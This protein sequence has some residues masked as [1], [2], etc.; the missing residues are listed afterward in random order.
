MK[1]TLNWL[2]QYVDFNWSPEELAER[3]TMLGLEVEGVHKLGG[4]FE[5]VVVA[6]V[7]TRDKHPNADKL[8]VCRVHDGQGERQIVC[9]AQNFQA[10]D[11]VPLVLPGAS[12]PSK[13]GEAP[14][15]IKV[16]KIR[17]V[18]SH[19]MMCSPKELGL[20]AEADGLLILPAD[21]R[22]G[23]PF[24]EHLGRSG[25]DVIYDLEIT[26]NRPDLNSVIGIAREIAAVTGNAL[27]I[28]EVR[29]QQSEVRSEDL[30]AVRIEDADLCPRYTA[31]VIRG[32]KIGPS[33]DWLRGALEKV[34]IRSIS[35]VV[36][37]TNYVM[38]ECGQPL[39]AF[40]YHLV[41]KGA[42]GKPTIVIRR[43][44]AGELFV[45]LDGQKH[46]LA[47]DNL[48]IADE[49]KGI[50][51]AGVMGGQNT[52]INERTVDVLLES[53]YFKP[54]NIRRTSKTTGLRTDASYRFERG[55]DISI[56][57]WASQRAAQL[58]LE[59]A[60]GQLAG[61]VVDAYPAPAEPRQITLRHAKVNELLGINLKPEEM[62]YY[63][64]QL[65]VRASARK[66]RPLDDTPTAPE[67][68]SFRI[69]TFRVDLKREIDLIE[70]V[71]RLHGVDK[72]PST[73]P[74]GAIGANAFDAVYD[75]IAEVR[76][77]LSGLGLSEATGQTLIAEASATLVTAPENLVPLSNPMS[78]DMNALRPSLLPGL[79]DSLRHNLTRK[80]N[81]VALFEVGRVFTM[82]N[83]QV[84]EERRV[85]MA[86]T[87]QRTPAF[88]SGGER[89]AKFDLSD[90][91]G[92][93][94]EFLEQSGL[95]GVT[96][97]RRPASTT[98]FLESAALQL[99]GKLALGEMGLLLPAL[100]KR[101]DLRDAVV[102]A[103]LSLDSL[104]ARR[105][106]A[107][108]FKTLP[109]FP[110]VRRDVA[111]FLTEEVTHDAVLGAVRQAKPQN[112]E[113]LELFDVFR[114]QHVPAGQKSVAYAFTYR[115]PDRTLTDNEVNAAHEKVVAQFKQALG[116]TV[117]E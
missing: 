106:A 61:G 71:A 89:D 6:Q 32:V 109:Q 26:P 64:N 99:G 77:I 16:G 54:T 44:Q 102:L 79:L 68:V 88:W 67:P 33:P 41:G 62:E 63:L 103:E 74:R 22:V 73:P 85:A 46:T 55:A 3:L 12:L 13:P 96:C 110:S 23:Q 39:H 78:S 58:I 9:G 21:A 87:G 113:A 115:H 90:L 95:R 104:L 14:F 35:N 1:V 93:V 50:A 5:G 43:A 29:S 107:R 101:Y 92:F 25:S 72:I 111:M 40:D 27:K 82:V 10:G 84:K 24:A 83:G 94:E 116:A 45:T 49:Q 70:E 86:L 30:V 19:G 65:G 20:A 48:L 114:G 42:D 57:D 28:P 80:N 100:A 34:G 112:L 81:D 15:T 91:K 7:I 76:R 31:R 18:E 66:P 38:M 60:G 51:L 108:S 52:E 11:K 4:E 105:N 8:S 59:T 53:A 75:Q 69:P 117:R 97:T 36:D 37:V 56:S 17:G 47:N 2:K 98:L